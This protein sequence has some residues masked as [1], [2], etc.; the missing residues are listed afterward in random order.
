VFDGKECCGTAALPQQLELTANG[1]S[2]PNKNSSA[3]SMSLSATA[4][5]TAASHIFSMSSIPPATSCVA[6]LVH[7]P[8]GCGNA[9]SRL[10]MLLIFVMLY[11]A[12][13]RW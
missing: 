12:K 5:I 2:I 10:F 8:P 13:V 7:G 1:N 11:Q 6:A 4:L 9:L 3:R